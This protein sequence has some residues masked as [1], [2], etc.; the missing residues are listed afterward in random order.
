M[1]SKKR[2]RE[3]SSWTGVRGGA[4]MSHCEKTG[5]GRSEAGGEWGEAGSSAR[6]KL[7]RRVRG[8]DRRRRTGPTLS[9]EESESSKKADERRTF[10]RLRSVRGVAS[11]VKRPERI[12]QGVCGQQRRRRAARAG[13]GTGTLRGRNFL[14]VQELGVYS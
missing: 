5:S 2:T 10:R 9:G 13:E 11:S 8:D 4:S 3:G 12:G 14:V 7:G 1:R 6:S